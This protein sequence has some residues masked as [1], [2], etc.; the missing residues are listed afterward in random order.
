MAKQNTARVP[1]EKWPMGAVSLVEAMRLLGGITRPTLATLIKSG[2]VK[3]ALVAS[4]PV[5]CRKSILDYLARRE[6]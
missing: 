6:N 5:V 3:R 1:V 2:E 4:K